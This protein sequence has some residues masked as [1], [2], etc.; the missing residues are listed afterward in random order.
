MPKL[1]QSNFPSLGLCSASIDGKSIPVE[2]TWSYSSNTTSG[3]TIQNCIIGDP[4]SWPKVW[5]KNPWDK[6]P[7]RDL[8]PER[9]IR[10]ILQKDTANKMYPPHNIIEVSENEQHLEYA[11][12]GMDIDKI[13]I[14][15]DQDTLIIDYSPDK[16]ERI[17][18]TKGIST[19]KFRKELEL[20]EY[21]EVKEASFNNGIL[22]I[23]VIRNIPEDKKPQKIKILH[24]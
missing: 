20:D 8:R 7:W 21:W 4:F 23:I 15:V 2:W 9:E 17:Y 16:D 13:E 22:T 11:V 24:K 5:P 18:K 14:T 6:Y 10:E 3:P 12:A 1:P 19:K